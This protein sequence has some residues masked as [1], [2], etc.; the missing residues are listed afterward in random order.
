MNSLGDMDFH[1]YLQIRGILTCLIIRDYVLE[2]KRCCLPVYDISTYLLI[3]IMHT[4]LL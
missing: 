3:W 1:K 4:I 2:S